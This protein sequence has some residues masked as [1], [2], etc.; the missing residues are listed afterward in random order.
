MTTTASAST[1][2]PLPGDS[3]LLR[4]RVRGAFQDTATITWRDMVRTARQ[5]EMLTFAVIMGV[6]FLVLFNYVFGGAIGAGTGVD[7]I[8]FVVPGVLV[9]TALQGAQQTGTGLAT[10][11]TEGVTDRFRSL[12]INQ[13]AV[14][15][16]RT[17]AD[18]AR[19]LVGL[20]LLA[21]VAMLMGF[22]FGSLSGAV[23]AVALTLAVGFAFSWLSASIAAKVRNPEMVGMLSMFWLFPL[24]LA[25]SAFAPPESMP[26]WLQGFVT[27]QP[28][29]IA[30]DAVR[31][32][33]SGTE[34]SADV[35]YALGWVVAMLAVF[36]PLS[37]RLYRKAT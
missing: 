37:S 7:Y 19:N 14:I 16:G 2:R 12:P 9:I 17:V 33:T 35:I 27:H 18:A 13:G 8:Q 10:D 20:V 28:I 24:M 31:S 30:A 3:S 29:S 15:A 34:A 36:I 23:A 1:A 6:F 5:P 21:G 25:S 11:L 4:H 22:R 26:G 32:L